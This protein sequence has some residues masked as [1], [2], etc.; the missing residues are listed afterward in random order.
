MI[1]FSKDDLY[2]L[3]FEPM[4]R[5][6]VWGG[7]KLASV[8]G[9]PIPPDHEPIGEAWEICDREG[10]ESEVVNGKL[11]GVTI[12]ELVSRLGAEFVGASF[13]GGRFPLLVKIIDAGQRLSLQVH[14]DEITSKVLGHGAEPKTEMWYVIASDPGAKIMVGLKPSTTRAQ[15]LESVQTPDVENLVQTFDSVPGDAFFIKAGRLHAIG[16]GN[17]L[18]EIQQNSNTTYRVND[19]GRVG[20]DGKPRELHLQQAAACIDF[21]DRTVARISG[22]ANTLPRNLK[23]PV[24][25]RCPY[26]RVDDLRLSEDWLDSTDN[27]RSFHMLTAINDAIDVE[28]RGELTHV[29]K[30]CTVLLPACLGNY[31]IRVKP[32]SSTTVVRTT[33]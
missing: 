21:L 10:A 31:A 18:L 22:P 3:L 2:P 32:G 30:G 12:R 25:N 13:R 24:V 33:L 29:E 20:L 19:W 27:P 7:T 17:L 4:Y 6:V 1:Q 26:F 28:Y 5:E 23:Y 8:L 16:A 11:A 15:F 9:R 14:P